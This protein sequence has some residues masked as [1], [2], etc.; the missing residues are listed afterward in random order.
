MSG[1]V[2]ATRL[3]GAA[4]NVERVTRL[5]HLSCDQCFE[6]NRRLPLRSSLSV[7]KHRQSKRQRRKSLPLEVKGEFT[8]RSIIVHTVT[9]SRC[10]T[11]R[12]D[13]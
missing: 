9:N 4:F 13:S 5:R 6:F 10:K 2:V 11:P 12:L 1:R 7:A 3:C 8:C